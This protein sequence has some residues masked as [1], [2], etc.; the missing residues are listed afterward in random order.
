M[1]KIKKKDNALIKQNRLVL[2]M[3][4]EGIRRAGS[5]ALS[6]FE[7]LIERNIENMLPALKEEMIV[8]GRKTL[9]AADVRA[10]LEKNKE[11]SW[12]V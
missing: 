6:I 9:K 4:K 11:K 12:E 5:E 1:A 7:E 8:H 3:K 10:V 2:M